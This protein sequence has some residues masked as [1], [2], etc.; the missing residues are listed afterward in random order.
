MIEIKNLNKYYKSGQGSFHA[1]RDINLTLPDKGIVFIAGK[2]GSG[3][4]TLLNVIGGIDSYDSGELI[5]NNTNT[6]KFN[7]KDYNAYR[8]TYIGFIFQ[9]FNVIK[10]L[11]V[12]ENIALSIQLHNKSTR[13]M[14]K[15]ILKVI[16]QVGLKGKENRKMNQISGGERQR[17]AIARSLVKN[18]D[19]II[20]DEPTGNLDPRNR[21]IV[22][23]I[24]KSLA[25]DR[26]VLIVTHDVFLANSY[27]ERTITLKD[28]KVISDVTYNDDH[29]KEN[30]SKLTLKQ[31]QPSILTSLILGLKSFKLNIV[32]YIFIILLFSVSLIFAGTVVN[33]FSADTTKEYANYQNEYNNFVVELNKTYEDGSIKVESGFNFVDYSEYT[34]TFTG[35]DKFTA[36]KSTILNFPVRDK[37]G[38]EE[39]KKLPV[40][41]FYKPEIERVNI[42]KD[43]ESIGISLNDTYPS[44]YEYQ[45]VITDYVA[46]MLIHYNYFE[47]KAIN[48]RDKL[49]GRYITHPYFKNRLQIIAIMKTPYYEDFKALYGIGADLKATKEV[50][51]NVSV[52]FTDNLPFYNAIYMTESEFYSE[53]SSSLLTYGK[54]V[55]TVIDNIIYEGLEKKGYFE[56]VTFTHFTNGLKFQG[57]APVRPEDGEPFQ[58]AVSKALLDKLYGS[59][60]YAVDANGNA[61]FNNSHLSPGLMNASN[62]M[63]NFKITGLKRSQAVFNFIVTAIVETENPDEIAV[64]LPS[65]MYQA[66]LNNSFNRGGN[67]VMTINND[68]D[69]NANIYRDMLNEGISIN[70]LSFTKLQIVNDFIDENLILFAAMFFVFCLFSVLMIFNFIIINIKNSTRDIGIYMSL[71]M[72]GF[73][74]AM[75]YFFQVLI[76]SIISLIIGMIGSG[77]FLYVLDMMFSQASAINFAIIKYTFLGVLAMMALAFI[78]PFLAI[79]F[80]LLNLSKKKPIDVLKTA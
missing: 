2:S 37:E 71:G 77:I 52:A 48:T 53:S 68:L 7:K 5:I 3:K 22:M 26:L 55:D 75:I 4:S 14:K 69:I 13:K 80:P 63:A 45:I 65:Y 79:C 34:T 15:E 20:A 60:S 8:N 40:D 36:Y 21:D 9:E 32:R 57:K 1:L 50:D 17:V 35:N 18:P 39:D 51:K 73:K 42:Y 41:S 64:Y 29:L 43:L 67:L 72:N 19:V 59:D 58:L 56:D 62:Y 31:I 54:N 44:N 24:L 74:I 61:V 23:G 47:N 46:D 27:G 16:E 49:L 11:T 25:K 28:G 38:L 33:L 78:T 10:S 30:D 76:V 66:Y 70:N 12:Y 6:K